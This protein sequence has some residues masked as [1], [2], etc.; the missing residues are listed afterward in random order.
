MTQLPKHV[1]ASS[2]TLFQ[3]LDGEAILLDL[4]TEHYY[5]LDDI[6]ARMWQLLAEQGDVEAVVAQLLDEYDVDEATLRRDLAN[7]IA[8]LRQAGLVSSSS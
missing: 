6:A 3:E 2:D 8:A 7:L 1:T 5:G 4:Q